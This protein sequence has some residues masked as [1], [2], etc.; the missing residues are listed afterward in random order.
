MKHTDVDI[1][2]YRVYTHVLVTKTIFSFVFVFIFYAYPVHSL[3]PG[4]HY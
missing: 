1:L 3:V 4:Y 2:Q